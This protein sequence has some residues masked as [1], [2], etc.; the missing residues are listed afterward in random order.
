MQKHIIK[1]KLIIK[2]SLSVRK[3]LIG[4]QCLVAGDEELADDEATLEELG[5]TSGAELDLELLVEGGAKGD[6]RYK[7]STSRFRWKWSKKRTR[8]LQKKRR[9]MR[10]RAR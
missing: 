10:M 4:I 7:K 5:L 6:S 9:K 3:T 1:S 2:P 8:R